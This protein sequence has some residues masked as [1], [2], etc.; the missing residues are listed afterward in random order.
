[1]KFEVFLTPGFAH[2]SAYI[3]NLLD[4]H[5]LCQSKLTCKSWKTFLETQKFYWQ[6][7]NQN[8]IG[9]ITINSSD[10]KKV[11]GKLS[12]SNSNYQETRLLAEMLVEFCAMRTTL[13][14]NSIFGLKI[15]L[16]KV[17]TQLRF[18]TKSKLKADLDTY[19]R[20]K[21]TAYLLQK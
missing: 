3:F 11:I 9:K 6:R 2:I 16:H 20:C 5:S 19:H 12:S 10:W 15:V 21:Q 18:L 4:N 14:Q 7:I 13:R 1:M 17:N 8:L